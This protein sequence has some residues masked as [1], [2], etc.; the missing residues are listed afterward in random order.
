MH[1]RCQRRA[2]AFDLSAVV[3]GHGDDRRLLPIGYCI[4]LMTTTSCAGGGGFNEAKIFLRW[5]RQG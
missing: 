3:A 1:R 4:K 2:V 5:L